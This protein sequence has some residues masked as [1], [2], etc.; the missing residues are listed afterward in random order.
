MPPGATGARSLGDDGAAD[1]PAPAG[2]RVGRGRTAE[3]LAAG[4][5]VA[6]PDVGRDTGGLDGPIGRGDCPVGQPI[7]E[8]VDGRAHDRRAARGHRGVLAVVARARP[9]RSCATRPARKSRFAVRVGAHTCRGTGT[10][11]LVTSAS[12]GTNSTTSNCQPARRAD[13]CTS[14]RIGLAS[15]F[16]KYSI[17]DTRSTSPA[18]S[19]PKTSTTRSAIS[20]PRP[21]AG[22]KSRALPKGTHRREP[23]HRGFPTTQIPPLAST[24]VMP[25][26]VRFPTRRFRRAPRPCP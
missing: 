16:A 22:R 13:G 14:S 1:Q 2:G 19:A 21:S 4:L 7:R 8:R 25:V 10:I 12:A 6:R 24:T 26:R 18:T 5:A 9:V 20:P 15:S 11:S 17:V 3:A 23:R